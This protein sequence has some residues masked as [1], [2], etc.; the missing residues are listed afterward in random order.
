MIVNESSIKKIT[1]HRFFEINFEKKYSFESIFLPLI[2]FSKSPN[3]IPLPDLFISTNKDL[4][5][6]LEAVIS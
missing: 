4:I 1:L 2:H 3:K 5:A 6:S